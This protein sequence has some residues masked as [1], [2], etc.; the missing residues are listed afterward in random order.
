MDSLRPFLPALVM[1]WRSYGYGGLCGGG[2]FF[3]GECA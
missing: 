3:F 1:I 2:M